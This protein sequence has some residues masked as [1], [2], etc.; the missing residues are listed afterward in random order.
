M[1]VFVKC[2]RK[3]FVPHF[4]EFYAQ[5]VF[6]GRSFMCFK[7]ELSVYLILF[8][9]FSCYHLFTGNISFVLPFLGSETGMFCSGVVLRS[10][11]EM[12][13]ISI[14][15]WV[16]EQEDFISRILIPRYMQYPTIVQ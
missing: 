13:N 5:H 16:F 1:S 4:I 7:S 6:N 12:N 8:M 9:C 14:F 11:T 2:R 10:S 3:T 15:L